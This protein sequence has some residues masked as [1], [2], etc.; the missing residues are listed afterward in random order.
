MLYLASTSP[1]RRQLLAAAG[2]RF[3]AVAPGPEPVGGGSPQQ[4]AS[5]RARSK[6]RGAAPDGPPGWVLGVD[7]VVALGDVDFGKPADRGAAATMLQ[8]L[9][10]QS[11]QVFSA[12]CLVS[13]PG[14][15]ELEATAVAVVRCGAWLPGQLDAYL[16][17]GAWRDKAG[18]YGI[19][20][21]V[22]DFMELVE[23]ATDTVIGL[24]LGLLR[25]LLA[26]GDRGARG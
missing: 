13:Y 22:C 10:G 7:T 23:G 17:S 3:A 18:G 15:A 20:D 9:G 2:I 16:D 21:A 11:H 8:A 24:P 4:R 19:Q 1:R 6:A 14:T 12:L 26:H 5:Q 25:Q